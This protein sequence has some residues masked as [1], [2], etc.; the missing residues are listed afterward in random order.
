ML[1]YLFG[2]EKPADE[3]ENPELA[4]REACDKHGEFQ[5]NLDGTLKFEDYIIFRAIVMR[6]S[7]RMFAPKKTELSVTKLAA[8]REKNQQAY[9]ES[10]RAGQAEFQKAMMTITKKA[11]EW[12]ELDQ[13]NYQ[14]TVRQYMEDNEKRQTLQ[15]K[16][17]EVRS[18]LEAKEVTETIK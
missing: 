5:H 15:V 7:C 9:V 13:P 12:I 14:L 3:N 2:G 8:F 10:F 17:S 16:D 11:C 4:M 6:Q 1:N 18:A